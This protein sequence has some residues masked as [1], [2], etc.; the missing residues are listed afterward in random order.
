MNLDDP[1]ECEEDTRRF[2][3]I[4]NQQPDEFKELTS[5]IGTHLIGYKRITAKDIN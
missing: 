3:E 1:R 2:C 4:V 5:V